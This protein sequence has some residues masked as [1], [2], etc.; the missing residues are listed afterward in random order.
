MSKPR[1][2]RKDFD[3][4]IEGEWQ[5][6]D[7]K[8]ILYEICCDCSLTHRMQIKVEKDGTIRWR[9]W[10]DDKQTK[11]NRRKFRNTAASIG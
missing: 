11:I 10:R 2:K 7:P 1:R 8:Q 3:Q 6:Y 4:V 9:C 5:L